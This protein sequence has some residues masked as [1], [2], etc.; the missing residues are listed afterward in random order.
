MYSKDRKNEANKMFII[1]SLVQFG[2]QETSAGRAIWQ[3]FDRRHERKLLLA[4][5]NN[6]TQQRVSEKVKTNFSMLKKVYLVKTK[7]AV[8]FS[9]LM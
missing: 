3:S 7:S 9:F 6:N 2:G 1:S 4:H 8:S 5:E